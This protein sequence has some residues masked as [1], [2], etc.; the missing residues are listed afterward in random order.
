MQISQLGWGF[1]QCEGAWF[2]NHNTRFRWNN[3]KNL[4]KFLYRV[5]NWIEYYNYN[6]FYHFLI[7]YENICQMFL[8][9]NCNK[10]L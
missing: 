8:E 7:S 10:H 9:K 3:N 2:I 4:L 1:T 5:S 6:Y